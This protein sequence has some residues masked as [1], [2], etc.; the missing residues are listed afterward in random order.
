MQKIK[1]MCQ[2]KECSNKEMELLPEFEGMFGNEFESLYPEME[3][4]AMPVNVS[5][6]SKTYIKWVQESL[7]KILGLSLATDGNIGVNTRSAIR[8]FQS[9]NGLGVDGMVGLRTEAALKAA[10]AGQLA[11][12]QVITPSISASPYVTVRQMVDPKKVDC[13][14]YNRSW[15]IFKA[16]GTT[17]P[18]GALEK[19]AQRAVEMLD[20]TISELKR[21]QGRIQ[22]GDPIAWPLLSDTFALS[23]RKRMSIKI[24]NRA[25]WTGDEPGKVGLVI[26]WLS[27]IRSRIAGGELWY[28]CLSSGCD[29]GT[30]AFIQPPHFFRI[31]FCRLFWKAKK[32]ISLSEHFEFQAQVLIHEVSHS[33]YN[34]TPVSD[35][36]GRGP[37]ISECIRQFVADTNNSPIDKDFINRCGGKLV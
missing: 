35:G 18:V 13:A 10:I 29:S 34:Q 2:C 22:A 14:K 15:P 16:L 33:Y 21:V 9:K 20:N 8:S 27:K 30:W 25:S 12:P 32:G 4:E 37:G 17:D 19:I 26:R 7:N 28:T 3:F 6:T 36:F 11:N 23:L 5:R 31:H 24:D 1:V